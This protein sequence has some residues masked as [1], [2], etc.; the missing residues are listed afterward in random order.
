MIQSERIRALNDL[1]VRKDG[2]YVLYWMQ[3]AQRETYN[4]AL[5]FSIE[6]A[7]DL[8]LPLLV[9]FGLMD[10]YPEANE[11]HYAFMLEGLRETAKRIRER[12]AAFRVYHGSPEKV[13]TKAAQ[14]AAIAVTDR[15]YLRHQK[16]WREYVASNAGCSV[17]QIES[18]AVVPVDSVSDK[19]EYAARTIRPKITRLLEQFL[20]PLDRRSIKVNQLPQDI[21]D[22]IDIADSG[23]LT[24]LT[25][26]RSVAPLSSLKGGPSEARRKLKD[27]INNKLPNYAKDRNDPA[28]DYTSGLSHYLHFGQISPV[29]IA[30]NVQASNGGKENIEDYLE[31]LIVRRELSFNFTHHNPH[32]DEYRCLPEWAMKTL[33]DH[34]EDKREYLYS[35]QELEEAATHDPYWNAAMIEMRNF[36][37]M[38]GYMRMYWGKKI[39]EWSEHPEEAFEQTLY[40]N[41]KYFV[42]GRD[43]NSYC[44]VAWIYGKHDRPWTERPIFGKI[45]YMNANGLKRKFD[46]EQ[47]VANVTQGS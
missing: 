20:Q 47:Y 9:V 21:P 24:Q 11:R 33:E 45:R 3:A 15:G 22:G 25:L 16:L 17:F 41:N 36:G 18:E 6:R 10:D 28:N 43:P 27:F 44:G 23:F 1:P 38:K 8:D 19:E 37:T 34:R 42:D 14:K 32:Y 2:G 12:G 4:H 13:A 29:Q 26:D 5:E 40:L 31:E 39:L 46:I 30:L 35:V 7:N